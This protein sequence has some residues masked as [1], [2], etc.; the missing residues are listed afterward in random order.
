MFNNQSVYPVPL[1][2]EVD[3]VLAGSGLARM[4]LNSGPSDVRQ[5]ARAIL[6]NSAG[7]MAVQ[8]LG[9]DSFY[10][11]PGG[12]VDDGESIEAALIREVKEEVGADCL[13]G[14]SLG[15]VVEYRDKYRLCQIADALTATVTGEIGEAAYEPDAIAAG[16]ETIWL[17][18][19]EALARIEA[20]SPTSYEGHFIKV[21]EAAFV[22]AYLAQTASA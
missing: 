2:V 17:P 21:R 16:Q 20:A 6:L 13:L 18:V 11:L 1:L 9:R 4:N 15:M 7:E 22:R 14:T 10:K 5:S 3:D 19:P 12:G 8:Y